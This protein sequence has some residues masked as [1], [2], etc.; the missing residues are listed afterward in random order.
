MNISLRGRRLNQIRLPEVKMNTGLK[1]RAILLREFIFTYVIVFNI[2]Q[3]YII[4]VRDAEL[5]NNIGTD[6]KTPQCG[7]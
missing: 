4:T 1:A 3:N 6:A 2:V 5:L 7:E